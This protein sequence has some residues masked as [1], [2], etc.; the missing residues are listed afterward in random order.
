VKKSA[1]V[2]ICVVVACAVLG[3]TFFR[4]SEEERIKKVLVELA[5]TVMVKEGDT[6]ISRT[7]RLRGRLP[8]LVDDDVRVNVPE[9]SVDLRGRPRF[10]EEATKA[11]LVYTSADCDFA[12]LQIK[13]DPASTTATVEAVAVVSGTRAGER[14][15]DKRNIHFLLHKDGGWKVS[16]IDV[17][18]LQN[19]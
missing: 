14:R 1:V 12:S 16:T 4:D 10:E 15:T 9:L 19:E 18:P 17:A 13:V 3:F 11:V 2:A 5:K 7:A 8:E 6:L